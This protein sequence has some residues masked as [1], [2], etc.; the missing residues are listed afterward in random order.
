MDQPAN[1]ERIGLPEGTPTW[2]V[3][4]LGMKPVLDAMRAWGPDLIY[5]HGQL[6]PTFEIRFL[7]IAPAIYFAHNY[8][9]TCIS[10]LKTFT[11]PIVQPCSRRFGKACL[12]HYFPRRCGGRSPVT[13]LRLFRRESQRLANLDKYAGIV[14]YSNHMREEYLRN[15][16]PA[17]RMHA[18]SHG[19]CGVTPQ[20]FSAETYTTLAC[21]EHHLPSRLLFVGRMERLKG[22]ETLLRGSCVHRRS[23]RSRYSC[24][25]CR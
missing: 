17:D 5:A 20:D 16:F 21:A 3:S 13:M 2:G 12:L 7:A 24:Q 4:R 22:G 6:A 9:G 11:F 1:R 14:T 19:I 8:Y 25:L 10:G 18:F 23:A 15:G